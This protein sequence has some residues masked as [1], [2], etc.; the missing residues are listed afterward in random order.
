MSRRRNPP[1]R[2]RPRRPAHP[3]PAQQRL[4]NTCMEEAL[5]LPTVP[6]PPQHLLRDDRVCQPLLRAIREARPQTGLLVAIDGGCHDNQCGSWGIALHSVARTFAG[7]LKGAD[8]TPVA[9]ELEALVQL[10]RALA[11]HPRPI[12]IL[13]DTNCVLTIFMCALNGRLSD[14]LPSFHFGTWTDIFGYLQQLKQ[15]GITPLAH[16]VPSHGRRRDI[17]V[18]IF[19]RFLN[20]QAHKAASL[21]LRTASR[22]VQQLQREQQQAAAAT[23]AR[24]QLQR[25]FAAVQDWLPEAWLSFCEGAP[26]DRF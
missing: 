8:F 20:D 19:W 11:L 15:A 21:A 14:V 6:G 3:A 26:R 10:L 4:A 9:A 25:L 18:P 16:W 23:W 17:D 2:R 13:F 12:R 22:R 5:A 7:P 1:P 24:A